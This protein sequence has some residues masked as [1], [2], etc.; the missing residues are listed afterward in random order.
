MKT[1]FALDALKFYNNLKRNCTI[2]YKYTYEASAFYQNMSYEQVTQVKIFTLKTTA[3]VCTKVLSVL[4]V[5]FD[6]K[7]KVISVNFHN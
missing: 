6:C 2:Q 4:Q 7:V 5:A 1:I 3:N